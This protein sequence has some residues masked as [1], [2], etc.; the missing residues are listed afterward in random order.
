MSQFIDGYEIREILPNFGPN[1]YR[2][3][4]DNQQYICKLMSVWDDSTITT[5]DKIK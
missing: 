1:I 3:L 2:A 5:Y 4:K